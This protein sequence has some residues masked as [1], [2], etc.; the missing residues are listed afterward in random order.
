MIEALQVER[1]N[2]PTQTANFPRKFFE[3]LFYCQCVAIVLVTGYLCTNGLFLN[4]ESLLLNDDSN[5][6]PKKWYLP[7]LTSVAI[8]AILGLLFQWFIPKYTFD[9][10]WAIFRVISPTS[11]LLLGMLLIGIGDQRG[12]GVG[13]MML[14]FSF[15]QFFYGCHVN[16]GF[17]YAINLL[18]ICLE[19]SP[20]GK[21][22]LLLLSIFTGIF[23]SSFFVAGMGGVKATRNR[24]DDYIFVPVILASQFWTMQVIRNV[25]VV[26]VSRVKYMNYSR[27][28]QLNTYDEF[29]N[30]TVKNSMGSVCIGSILVPVFGFVDASS[31]AVNSLADDGV[32][33]LFCC[34][35]CFSGLAAKLK[36]LGNEWGFVQ[37][38]A[39]NKGII[40]ASMDTWDLLQN[41]AL[42]GLMGL[43]RSD[44]TESFCFFSGVAG[45]AICG[46]VS[47]GWALV[48]HKNYALEVSLYAFL[49]GYFM[50]RIAMA[51][52]HACVLA[53]Y[54]AYAAYPRT[55]AFVND[56]TIPNRI[57]VIQRHQNAGPRVTLTQ[58]EV[59]AIQNP[60]IPQ[61]L[62]EHAPE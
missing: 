56:N 39:H 18:S 33:C 47:G 34:A 13:I 55:Q 60:P 4:D 41:N 46:L 5:F 14:L 59:D 17:Q 38:G 32:D 10:I 30:S 15:V 6:H 2:P 3:Y 42:E 22:G 28:F 1:N 49:I 37:V 40:R 27:R 52:P 62:T 31:R 45:G 50:V 58:E 12:L 29:R 44:L 16:L 11:T 26:T 35:G 19:F 21:N 7:L 24:V 51:W 57:A 36:R 53:Y 8:S 25:M 48:V 23:Y 20:P 54:V 61:D 43:I 9:T